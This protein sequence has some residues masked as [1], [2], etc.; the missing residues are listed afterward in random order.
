MGKTNT[1]IPPQ[2]WDITHIAAMKSIPL[3]TG[4]ALPSRENI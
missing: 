3:A 1:V 4:T 2:S